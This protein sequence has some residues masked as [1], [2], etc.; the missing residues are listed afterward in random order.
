MTRS[1]PR[2]GSLAGTIV[3]L[4]TTVAAIAVLLTGVVAWQ[5][6]RGTAEAHARVQMARQATVLSRVPSMSELLLTGVQRIAGSNG[7][8]IAVVNP[9]GTVSGGA[10]AA[11]SG[12]SEDALLAG[13]T[14]SA[15][16]VLDGEPVLVEGHP[17]RSGGAVVLAKP[18]TDVDAAADRIRGSLVLPLAVGM[19]GAALAGALLARRIARPLAS[20]A[21]TA[22]RLAAGGRG[23]R[24][25]ADGP[26]EVAE[27]ARALNTLDA[28]LERSERRQREFLLSVS[29]EIRTPLTA[30][31]GYAEALAD[32]MVAADGVAEAGRTLLAESVRLDR[33]LHDL[34]DL[35][36]LEADDFRLTLKPTDLDALLRKTA[37]GWSGQCAASGVDLRLE[38]P[39][40]SGEPEKPGKPG[41]PEEPARSLV[42]R[43]DG[44]RVR[45]L[46]D[47]LVE[48]ALRVTPAGRPLVLALREL[49]DGGAE[50]HVRDGGPGLTDVDALVAF[51]R[52]VLT[53][54]YRGTRPV[55]S[56]LGLAIAHR[57]VQ[58]LGGTIG[59]QGRGPEGGA[60][61]AVT[62]PPR[63]PAE[64]SRAVPGPAR[65]LGE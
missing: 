6:A 43:T 16:A 34:L 39:G 63:P 4:A 59:V 47:G 46:L 60:C 58:R 45:Q 27:V 53:D 8:R 49:P 33:F 18:F 36:R 41:K 65:T 61:F 51:E 28:A 25:D 35:A 24:C 50:L 13:R 1:A 38:R 14:V 29:H 64:G 31:Q 44:F 19:V 3:L 48:N 15:T 42:V 12:L 20:A 30:L 54:R 10:V 11:V 52:G 55:G 32:G 26:T 9:D 23:L 37:A 62:L 40:T 2:R 56:G 57:L 22:H 5:T 7:T 21:G 17:T